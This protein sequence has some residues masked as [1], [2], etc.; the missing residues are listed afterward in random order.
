MGEGEGKEG[1]VRMGEEEECSIIVFF[2]CE[3]KESFL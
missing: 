2:F 1:G 3:I